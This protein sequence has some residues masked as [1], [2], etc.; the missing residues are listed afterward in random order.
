M[1]LRIQA[2]VCA[3][4]FS[5][6]SP[7][8]VAHG[9]ALARRAGVRLYLVHAIHH[10]QDDLHPTT[11]FERGGDL[12]AQR[13]GAKRRMAALMTFADVAWE[14][15]VC[16][17]EP[18]AQIAAQ[19]DRLPP[20]LVVSAS[21]GVSG[22][23]RLFIG[24]VV[25]RLTRTLARPMLVVKPGDAARDRGFEGF[26]SV[27]I[28][29]DLH[30]YWRRVAPLLPLLQPDSGSDIHL[31]HAME[32]PRAE[33]PLEAEESPYDQVQRVH[34]DRIRREL[35]DSARHLFPRVDSSCLS[36]DVAS[37]VPQ[38][39]LLQ[40]ARERGAELVVVGVRPS[41]KVGRWIAGS[42]TETLLRRSPCA[43]LTLPEP[44]EVAQ[45]GE[46]EP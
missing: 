10:P 29:C 30:G 2:I 22:F 32:G 4:D 15:V 20:S 28:G 35:A 19:V 45:N 23:R 5:A 12:T 26:R 16:F 6:F 27:V 42:T 46:A 9:V 31:V 44:K 18:V 24:T 3:V 8:V 11:L 43:V 13:E 36:I 1:P 41:G 40:A 25:E 14:A 33:V 21:L 38:E 34:Q 7:L 39:M 37:G 17:G